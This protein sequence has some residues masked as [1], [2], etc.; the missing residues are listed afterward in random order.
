MRRERT[1]R[2]RTEGSDRARLVIHSTMALIG[3]LYPRCPLGCASDACLSPAY[4]QIAVQREGV[5]AAGG[6][7]AGL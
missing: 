5:E 7:W 6:P 4:F 1:Q 2:S 3:R